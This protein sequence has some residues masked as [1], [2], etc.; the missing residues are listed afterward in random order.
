MIREDVI[1]R[2]PYQARPRGHEYRLTEKGLGLHPVIMAIVHWGDVHMAGK[3]GRPLLHEHPAC[4]HVF[5]P[6][7]SCSVCPG[8]GTAKEARVRPRPGAK[9]PLLAGE[10][11]YSIRQPRAA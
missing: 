4:G 1:A 7:L 2:I 9:P 8:A 5:D 10:A 3:A 6:V 11:S